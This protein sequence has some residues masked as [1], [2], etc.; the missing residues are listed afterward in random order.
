MSPS[1]GHGPVIAVCGHEAGY[2]EALRDLGPG[3]LVVPGGRELIRAL[4]RLRRSGEEACVV[5]MTLGRDPGLV[6]DTARTLRAL[7]VA[8]RPG[9]LLAEPFGTSQHLIAWLR[10]AANR[11][12]ETS[13]LLVT[14]PVGDPFDD[15]ELYRVASLVHRYGS[16]P[17]VEVAFTGG[18]P[19]PAE[20]IRRCALLGA[21]RV[22]LLP[23]AF[24]LPETPRAADTDVTAAGPLLPPAALVRVLAERVSDARR[25]WSE[26]RDDGIA[27][28]LTAADDHGHSHT[29]PPGEGHGHFPSHTH[30]TGD[31]PSHTHAPGEGHDD[32]H[33]HTHQHPHVHDAGRAI[34]SSA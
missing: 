14:A 24:G 20:G 6:A 5:P 21:S 33:A 12:P 26:R 15:A 22:T 30:P 8:E 4:G 27:A 28:G 1:T 32:D 25:R 34:R 23:A 31:G 13:A 7:P 11:T 19:D 18:A 17:V 3:V 10:A 9:T 2:G 29:H 16:H